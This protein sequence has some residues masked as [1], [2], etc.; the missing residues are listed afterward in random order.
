MP[1]P[2]TSDDQAQ[3]ESAICTS[4]LRMFGELLPKD[5]PCRCHTCQAAGEQPID[6]QPKTR[7]MVRRAAAYE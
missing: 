3:F 6:T 5:S 7:R 4:L 1:R 2:W